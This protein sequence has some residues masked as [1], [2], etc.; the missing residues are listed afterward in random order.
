ML[1]GHYPSSLSAKSKG[2]RLYGAAPQIS[3][4]LRKQGYTTGAVT[5]G[6]YVASDYGAGDGFDFFEKGTAADAVQWIMKTEKPFFL[7]FHTYEPHIPYRDRRFVAEQHRDRFAEIYVDEQESWWEQHVDICCRAIEVSPEEREYVRA[8]Y[9]G[10]IA[11]ADEMVQDLVNAVES[12][13]VLDN[14]IFILTSDHGEEFWEHTD[15]GAYHGHTL[16]DELARIPLIWVDPTIKAP[17]GSVSAPVNL[18]DIVP[19]LMSR[20][21]FPLPA[22]VDGV[23]LGP[24]LRDGNRQFE[25]P[26]FAEF[27]GHGP[28]RYSVR[29]SS[30]KLIVTPDPKTQHREGA[31]FPVPVLAR[32]ELYL[33]SDVDERENVAASHPQLV[34]D[35]ARLIDDHRRAAKSAS[36]KEPVELDPETREELRALGY[37]D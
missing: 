24:L 27:T 31:T 15:R 16:Y 11:S 17:P 7:F 36:L 25:R 14:T 34:E 12:M 18:V 13:A 3:S 9:D 22:P 21:G 33:A 26:I 37:M 8:L 5:G 30:A 4:L 1:S 2:Q 20:L 19:T 35:L 32:Q 23:D 10:G 6:G 29:N 28:A